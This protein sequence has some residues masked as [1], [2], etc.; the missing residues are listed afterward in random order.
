MGGWYLLTGD[1]LF[2]TTVTLGLVITFLAYVQRFNQPIQQIAV[3]WTNIQNAIAG[4]ERIFT[5]LDE[6]PAVVDKPE[7]KAMTE[8]KGKVEF[9]EVSMNMKT[10]CLS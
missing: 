5:I 8:I 2:G 7:A 6:K 1:T 10:A 4:A 9:N 3:L